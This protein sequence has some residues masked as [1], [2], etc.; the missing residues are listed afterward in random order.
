MDRT[1]AD[2]EAVVG[3]ECHIVSGSHGGPRHE[4]SVV[5]DCIDDYQNLILLCKV[6]HKLVDDQ[7]ETYTAD[8]LLGLKERHEAWVSE[9]LNEGGKTRRVRI[10]RIRENVPNQLVRLM[11][12]RALLDIVTNAQ[13]YAFDNDELRSK[14]ESDE[15]AGFLQ[16]L[17]DWGEVGLTEAGEIVSASFSLT[18]RI[19]EM[20]RLG[21]WVFGA[22]EQQ[23]LEG[24]VGPSSNWT[25]AIVRVVRNDNDEIVTVGDVQHQDPAGGS[26]QA[27]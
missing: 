24:G 2:D 12:G 9:Q 3:D 21:F 4:P 17:Q 15:I 26:E 13:S 5:A 11:S 27:F 23:I 16:E 20:E 7:S 18:E 25:M 1:P 6:H 14:E 19:Q 10:R 8:L 22:R